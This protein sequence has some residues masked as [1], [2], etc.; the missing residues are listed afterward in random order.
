MSLVD[1]LGPNYL[2]VNRD[3][4]QFECLGHMLLSET[5]LTHIMCVSDMSGTKK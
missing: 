4:L 3:Y 1:N 5:R 2:H